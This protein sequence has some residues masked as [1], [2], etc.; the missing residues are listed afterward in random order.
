MGHFF[1][2]VSHKCVHGL[3]SWE[4]LVALKKAGSFGDLE[5][6]LMVNN[7]TV[8]QETC[9]ALQQGWLGRLC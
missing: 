7:I 8:F 9:L 2:L 3:L 6:G 4:D 5:K 1:L